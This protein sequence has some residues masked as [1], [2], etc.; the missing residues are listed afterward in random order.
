[1]AVPFIPAMDPCPF[2]GEVFAVEILGGRPVEFTEYV[3]C[4]SCGATGP[5]AGLTPLA[6]RLWNH[7]PSPESRVG[8]DPDA[9]T[10]QPNQESENGR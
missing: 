9:G 1:M 8:L 7:R 10:R 4:G 5:K 2:C 3:E 6:V